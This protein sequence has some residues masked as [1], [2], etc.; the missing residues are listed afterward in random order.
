VSH[1]R[2]PRSGSCRHPQDVQFA[3]GNN[4]KKPFRLALSAALK[5]RDMTEITATGRW[6]RIR[7]TPCSF[8]PA[9][10][11]STLAPRHR[12]WLRELVRRRAFH[13]LY[14]D[15]LWAAILRPATNGWDAGDAPVLYQ[16]NMANARLRSDDQRRGAFLTTAYTGVVDLFSPKSKE[17][18]HRPSTRRRSTRSSVS[19]FLSSVTC[20]H[21]LETPA[22]SLRNPRPQNQLRHA[23]AKWWKQIEDGAMLTA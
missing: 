18:A 19:T 23:V 6:H 16:A 12:N 7:Q 22:E 1:Q 20:G 2:A 14:V 8:I 17:S 21:V 4:P 10:A 11:S 9:A 15:G 3:T 13:H 5:R